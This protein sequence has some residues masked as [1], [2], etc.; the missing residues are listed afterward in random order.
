MNVAVMSVNKFHGGLTNPRVI[1]CIPTIK[2]KCVNFKLNIAYLSDTVSNNFVEDKQL[3]TSINDLNVITLTREKIWVNNGKLLLIVLIVEENDLSK[4]MRCNAFKIN[5]C[6]VNSE[7]R[8][9]SS[10]TT[11]MKVEKK[12][13]E[14]LL[15]KIDKYKFAKLATEELDE[16]MDI[17]KQANKR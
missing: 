2:Y 10:E 16:I 15:K 12:H 8:I 9:I 17:L 6:E 11:I 1:G 5:Y 14:V 7:M 3:R 4:L 13:R